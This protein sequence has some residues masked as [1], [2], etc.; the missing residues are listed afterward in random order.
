MLLAEEREAAKDSAW[1]T[2]KAEAA[3]SNPDVKTLAT[4]L[5]ALLAGVA[6]GAGA[7][8]APQ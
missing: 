5:E 8:T 2:F 3:K 4:L 1:A 6:P 7:G